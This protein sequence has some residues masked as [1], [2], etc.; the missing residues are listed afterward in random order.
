MTQVPSGRHRLLRPGGVR[1]EGGTGALLHLVWRVRFLLLAWAV[2][3]GG[4]AAQAESAMPLSTVMVIG[5]WTVGCDHSGECTMIGFPPLDTGGGRIRLPMPLRLR[6]PAGDAETPIIET[7]GIGGS[8]G[9][10]DGIETTGPFT[11]PIRGHNGAQHHIGTG[12]TRFD[13]ATA[14]IIF[15]MLQNGVSLK[16]WNPFHTLAIEFPERGFADAYGVMRL[17]RGRLTELTRN[18]EPA[19]TIIRGEPMM[20]PSVPPRGLPPQSRCP[21]G[22]WDSHRTRHDLNAG[23][24]LWGL[25]CTA[26]GLNPR[27]F[28]SILDQGES[29][30]KPLLL[31]HGPV[32]AID[33]ATFGLTNVSIDLD[34]GVLRAQ[35]F[36]DTSQSCGASWVWGNTAQG[37]VLIEKRV[38]PLCRGVPIHEWIPVYRRTVADAPDS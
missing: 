5:D 31:P 34:F 13:A 33:A 7:M 22:T 26:D 4:V 28:F 12:P 6:F 20:L 15:R 1:R 16:A 25:H 24:E 38:M 14:P 18:P 29:E 2:S 11:L 36:M 3:L 35:F 21:C 19:V 8:M 37:F 30:A 9:V 23:R 32:E 17:M 27:S 10:T